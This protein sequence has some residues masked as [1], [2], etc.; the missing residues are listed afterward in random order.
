DQFQLVLRAMLQT[1]G[2]YHSLIPRILYG[3]LSTQDALLACEQEFFQEEGLLETDLDEQ[4]RE[5]KEE[6]VVVEAPAAPTE[7]TVQDVME[8]VN[9]LLEERRES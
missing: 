8:E 6:V 1:V 7:L 3:N 4:Y 2:M 5:D 9:R